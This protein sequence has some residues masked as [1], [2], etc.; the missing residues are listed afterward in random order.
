MDNGSPGSG[1]L[2]GLIGG[3]Q[4]FNATTLEFDFVPYS[5]TVRFRYV[6]GSEEYP[7]FAH[8]TT[9]VSTMFSV[10]LSQV[11][12]LQACKILHSCPVVAE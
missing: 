11:P 10:S 5:D 9:L 6:F 12:A 8:L 4:T 2:S 1:L 3:A 7:E